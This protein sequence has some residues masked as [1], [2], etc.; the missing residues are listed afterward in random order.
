[1]EARNCPG[2]HNRPGGYDTHTCARVRASACASAAHQRRARNSDNYFILPSR[3][4]NERRVD[5]VISPPP[6][7]RL[8]YSPARLMKRGDFLFSPR[9]PRP[10]SAP[11]LSPVL[12]RASELRT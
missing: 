6:S 2:S 4:P 8:K 3:F 1:M 9:E 11:Y 12:R 5:S 10:F 7:P